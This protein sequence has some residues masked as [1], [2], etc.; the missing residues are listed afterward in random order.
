MPSNTLPFSLDTPGSFCFEPSDAISYTCAMNMKPRRDHHGCCPI[1]VHKRTSSP[2]YQYLCHKGEQPG[3]ARRLK[4]V[5]NLRLGATPGFATRSRQSGRG[6][7][8][9]SHTFVAA[10]KTSCLNIHLT[11]RHH[12]QRDCELVLTLQC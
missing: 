1:L 12:L 8:C 5:T 11:I 3:R 4:D 10:N 2:I 9:I 7:T 6:V